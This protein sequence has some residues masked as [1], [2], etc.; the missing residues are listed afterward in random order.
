MIMQNSNAVNRDFYDGLW[1]ESQLTRPDRFNTWSLISGLLPFAPARLEIGPGL[2]PRLPITGTC[3]VDISPPVVEQLMASGGIAVRAEITDLPFSD[4]SFELVCAFDVIEHVQDDRRVFDEVSR[5]LKEDGSFILSVPAHAKLW[6]KFD[7][8]VG[9]V[10]RYDPA[11]LTTLLA[12]YGL[13]IE[14]SAAYG[15]QPANPKLLD[16]GLWCLKHSRREAMWVYNKV[17]MP[18]GMLFQKRLK[19]VDGLIDATGVDE[20]V[21]VCRKRSKSM[22][23]S[24]S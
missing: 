19:F 12:G 9:H 11:D 20:I 7:E 13:I 16:F 1:S 23:E 24:R 8:F 15:M 18:L 4:G 5:V 21:L 6:T 22:L 10:R 17:L 3:F 14:K 2:R